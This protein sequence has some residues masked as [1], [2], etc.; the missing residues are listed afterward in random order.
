[1]RIFILPV[2]LSVSDSYG[3][4]SAAG[5]GTLTLFPTALITKETGTFLALLPAHSDLTAYSATISGIGFDFGGSGPTTRKISMT[6]CPFF[7]ARQLR[8]ASSGTTP[9][10]RFEFNLATLPAIVRGATK[11]FLEGTGTLVDTEGVY[12][13]TPGLMTVKAF[14]VLISRF[15]FSFTLAAVPEP[16]TISLVA[17]RV[18]G[19]I[20]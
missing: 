15:P 16:A 3:W 8:S 2:P 9:N 6:I 1:M 13:N 20:G 17:T 5:G 14:P 4:G 19:R 11:Y 10:N 7:H 18:T 12:A